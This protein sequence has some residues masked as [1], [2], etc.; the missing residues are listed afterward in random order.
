MLV[1]S[2]ML[3]CSIINHLVG[4]VQMILHQMSSVR[5]T[6]FQGLLP[7]EL[8]KPLP[9]ASHAGSGPE[10]GIDRCFTYDTLAIE[11][12]VLKYI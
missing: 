10:A 12:R 7:P 3:V 5:T 9:A 6:A 8:D 1:C 11:K 4:G 2:R